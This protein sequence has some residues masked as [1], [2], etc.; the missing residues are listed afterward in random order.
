MFQ[1]VVQRKWPDLK[2]K[3]VI[4]SE[5]NRAYAPSYMWPGGQIGSS[6]IIILKGRGLDSW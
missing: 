6:L 3:R 5:E 4:P 1:T 2:K